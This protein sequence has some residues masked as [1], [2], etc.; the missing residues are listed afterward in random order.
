MARRRDRVRGLLVTV[1]IG[2]LVVAFFPDWGVRDDRPD[3]ERVTEVRLG[4][5]SSPLYEWMRRESADG[6]FA[7]RSGIHWVSW[8]ALLVLVAIVSMEV[9]RWRRRTRSGGRPRLTAPPPAR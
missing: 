2:S 4:L 7:V 9:L 3:G 6:G 8:S 5:P 1:T